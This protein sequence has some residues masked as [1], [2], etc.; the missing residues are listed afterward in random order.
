MIRSSLMALSI[1]LHRKRQNFYVSNLN[2]NDE[3]CRNIPI[4]KYSPTISLF[5]HHISGW[6]LCN[7]HILGLN[8]WS[9]MIF[10]INYFTGNDTT[11]VQYLVVEG[12]D[13]K[14]QS[15]S[16]LIK[17]YSEDMAKM[18]VLLIRDVE[19]VPSP[20]AMAFH[21]YCDE[22]NPLVKKSAVFFT[23]NSAKCHNSGE[24]TYLIK[25]SKLYIPN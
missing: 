23:L 22:F 7:V 19:H 8:L 13:L 18:G 25:L 9:P 4:S 6:R 20:L 14:M 2:T 3:T 10:F 5:P 15:H 16:Q 21:Y 24:C 1:T 17:A 11:S 12:S